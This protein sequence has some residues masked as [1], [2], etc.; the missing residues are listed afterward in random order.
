MNKQYLKKKTIQIAPF[1]LLKRNKVKTGDLEVKDQKG[2]MGGI[3]SE[4]GGA[5]LVFESPLDDLSIFNARW[6]KNIILYA[7]ELLFYEEK[8]E[9]VV[10]IILRFNAF[11]R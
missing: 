5:S 9:R 3:E 7:V 10:D 1:C 11:S 8:W 4:R 2:L 6:L